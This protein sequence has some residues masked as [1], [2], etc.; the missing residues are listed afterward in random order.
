MPENKL[1]FRNCIREL[2][3]FVRPYRIRLSIALFMIIVTNLT[4]AL[5][6][7]MEGKITTQLAS[8]GAK[9]LQGVPGAHVQFS[10]LFRFMGILLCLYILKTI[11]QLITS[12]SSQTPFRKLCMTS[13]MH[14]RKKSSVSRS[15]ILMTTHL[16]IF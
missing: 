10:I 1:T 11:S 2:L 16:E 12:V 5:N 4:F 7:M 9:I 6:P 14:C 8:D 3:G 13:A 15:N